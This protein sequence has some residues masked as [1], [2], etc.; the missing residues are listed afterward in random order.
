MKNNLYKATNSFGQWVIVLCTK[1]PKDASTFTGMA[2]AFDKKG[3]E[4]AAQWEIGK[5]DSTW[6]QKSFELYHPS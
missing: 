1:E 4:S 6:S 5:I 3:I 2:V